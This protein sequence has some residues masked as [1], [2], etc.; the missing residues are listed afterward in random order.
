MLLAL[1]RQEN[2]K[3]FDQ[4]LRDG[5]RDLIDIARSAI[6]G[7]KA[8]VA[9][10]LPTRARSSII[11]LLRASMGKDYYVPPL[12]PPPLKAGRSR[13]IVYRDLRLSS[14]ALLLRRT[15]K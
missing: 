13:Q 2:E 12:P 6:R 7:L 14:F 9:P 3:D 5:Q 1:F 4:T 10:N 11:A 8:G 15:A